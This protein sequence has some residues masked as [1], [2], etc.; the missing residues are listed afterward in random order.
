MKKSNIT[1]IV[2]IMTLAFMATCLMAMNPALASIGNA[3]PEI[4]GTTLTLI[5]TLSM[6]VVVPFSLLAGKVA[7]SKVKYRTLALVGILIVSFFGIL[8]YFLN[9]FYIILISRAF[10]GA[11]A[12][13]ISPLPSTL[14]MQLFDGKTRE[15]LMGMNNLAFNAG[16]MVFQLIAGLL[17][18]IYW[19]NTFF[20]YAICVIGL[21]IVFFMLPEPPR[22]EEKDENSGKKEGITGK[23]YFWIFTYVLIVFFTYPLFLN[24]SSLVEKGNLGTAAVSGFI[25]TMSTVGG[26]VASALFG[27]MF[28][29]AKRRTVSIGFFLC[30]VSYVI[31]IFENNVVAFTMA[32]VL[33]GLGIGFVTPTA[34]MY[35]GLEVEPAARPFAMSLM[36]GLPNLAMFATS[37]FFSFIKYI[38]NITYPRYIFVIGLVFY[39]ASA[40]YFWF[41][42][43]KI[44]GNNVKEEQAFDETNS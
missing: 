34:F 42:K 11:G 43:I 4:D 12:G 36:M 6:L 22:I 19:R 39:A 33:S 3:F 38:F 30:A 13:I 25:L 5:S 10:C 9:N 31:M 44:N 15:N 29:F 40:I 24:M 32:S 2:S 17:C 26:I 1:T 14:I 37:Y 7:G 18:A 21:M 8:P 16:G 23:A 27:M 41:S 28:R 20:V 35:L